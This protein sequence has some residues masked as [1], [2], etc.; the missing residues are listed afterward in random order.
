M[1]LAAWMVTG[2]T[3][4]SVY[5]IGMLRGR[6]SRYHRYGLLIPLTAAS[7]AA[8]IQI[9][10]GDWIANV[11]ADT[12]PVKL[13]A[14]EAQTETQTGAPLSLGGIY[15]DGELKGA[16]E[17]PNGLSLLVTHDPNSEVIGL[18]SV[19]EDLRPPVNIVHLSYD[20]MVGIGFALLGL[21]AWFWWSWWRKREIPQTSWFLR[22]VGVSG[23]AAWW[24]CRP[25][26]SP[27]RWAGNPGSCTRSSSRATP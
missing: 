22:A 10:V 12:Q 14:M 17:I 4:A 16:I 24:R 3:V 21:S 5:A 26:G 19:P 27:P 6:R 15:I 1:I 25:G 9:G 18:E 13:A 2:F 20:T 23:L 8:P 11:V 7:V